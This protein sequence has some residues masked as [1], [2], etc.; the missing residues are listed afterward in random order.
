MQPILFDTS[1]YITALR[2]G[3]TAVLGT[4]NVA[5]GSPLWLSAVVLE[6]LYAGADARGRKRLAKF[7]RDFVKVNRLLV[8]EANEWSRTGAVLAQIGEKYGYEKIGRA[9]LTN[10]TLIGTSAARQ[11][12]VLL[13]KNARDFGLIAEFCPLQYQL[14]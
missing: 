10:D 5:Y 12:I 13:T 2:Q 3:E 14:V 4:R 6:E 8:P 9:R 7:E 1:V 11:G